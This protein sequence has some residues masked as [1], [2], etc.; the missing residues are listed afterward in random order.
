MGAMQWLPSIKNG[1]KL[2][3]TV[4]I[5]TIPLISKMVYLA[6]MKS[7]RIKNHLHITIKNVNNDIAY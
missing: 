6:K 3:L 4:S 5:T 7:F 2:S 1:E